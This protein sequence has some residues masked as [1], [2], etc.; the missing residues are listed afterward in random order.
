MRVAIDFAGFTSI[1]GFEAHTDET[2]YENPARSC[3][4]SILFDFEL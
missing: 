3:R 2:E 1:E 4:Y